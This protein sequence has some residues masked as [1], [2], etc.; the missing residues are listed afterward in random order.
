MVKN[1]DPYIT[2]LTNRKLGVFFFFYVFDKSV[3]FIMFS[4]F[5]L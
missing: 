3:L 5:K 1:G 2:I 4:L